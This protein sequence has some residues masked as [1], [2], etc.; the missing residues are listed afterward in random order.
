MCYDLQLSDIQWPIKR[1]L[2]D[3]LRH[4]RANRRPSLTV[5]QNVKLKESHEMLGNN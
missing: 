1:N 3:F 5:L 4:A 2:L